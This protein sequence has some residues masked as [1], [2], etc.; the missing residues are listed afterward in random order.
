[1]KAHTIIWFRKD[2]RLIDNP[3]L[4]HATQNTDVLAIYI[5]DEQHQDFKMGAASRWWL[6]HSLTA[7]NKQL[8]NKLN[9]YHG[10][11]VEIIQQ[12]IKRY[13]IQNVYW[14]ICYEP[15]YIK[16]DALVISALEK[17][18]ISCQTFN[19][20]L[21]WDP[22]AI[23]TKDNTTY[24][25][26]TPFY[27]NGC[28][29]I[30]PRKPFP[31]AKKVTF[32]RD[33]Q[34]I[35]I[36]G[37]PLLENST[38][39]TWSTSGWVP[40]EEGAHKKFNHFIRHG[41]QQYQ[42]GRNFPA[43]AS[44]SRLSPHIHFGEISPHYIWEYM[45]QKV[46]APIE[47]KEIAYF[48]R[49]LAWREFSYYVLYHFPELPRE[50]FQKKFDAF[51]W[52]TDMRLLQ[53]WQ[54]GATGYPLVDAGMRELQQTGYMHN[55]IRMVVGS[56][57]VKNLLLHWHHGAAWFWDSLFDAD[58]ANNSANWQWVA[59]SGADAAPYFRIFNPI[60]Q[61]TKFDPSGDYTRHFVPE[62]KRLPN[63]Y[64]FK[65]WQAPGNLLQEIGITLGKTYPYP[66]VDVALSRQKALTTFKKLSQ[67]T[68]T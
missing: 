16:N 48:L 42:E 10:S 29:G 59:G 63:K 33:T 50:N 13:T 9:V 41:L 15:A 6:H 18:G 51:A 67:H 62:L 32:I 26:F 2:L 36:R 46:H 30:T 52:N 19:G 58:L 60:T 5:L 43:Q 17:K 35:I 3:A 7:L 57:L 40:G 65:P 14:N 56:F 34:S 8:D 12:L 49:E 1:M 37:L 61:G 38:Q 68:H 64:L 22:A 23:K 27:K 31:T 53:A 39:K 20:S 21:L 66:I 47:Q 4:Y 44:V 24:K 11:A 45:H 55:R 25:I 28:L 54:A